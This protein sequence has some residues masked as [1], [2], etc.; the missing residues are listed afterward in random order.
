MSVKSKCHACLLFFIALFI[1]PTLK[2]RSQEITRIQANSLIKKLHIQTT[3]TGKFNTLVNLAWF[4]ILKPG[5]LKTDLDSAKN[6][7]N[8]AGELLNRF[9]SPEFSGFFN[10]VYSDYYHESGQNKIS[11]DAL[12]KATNLL[13][14]GKNKY[15]L[16]RAYQDSMYRMSDPESK[17]KML[18]LAANEFRLEGNMRQ[19]G[20]CLRLIADL[21]SFEPNNINAGLL[22]LDS[23]KHLYQQ[24]RSGDWQQLY[25]VYSRYYALQNN[26]KKSLEAILNALRA[27]DIK[28]T[29][30]EVCELDL[31]ASD[32]FTKL[33]DPKQAL[34]YG[35]SALRLAEKRNNIADIYEISVAVTKSYYD[36]GKPEQGLKLLDALEFKYPV[37]KFDDQSLAHIYSRLFVYNNL[38]LYDKGLPYFNLLKKQIKKRILTDNRSI[39]QALSQMIMFCIGSGRYDQARKMLDAYE[40]TLKK[41]G[42]TP[43]THSRLLTKRLALDTATKD[44]KSAM[45]HLL[46]LKAIS[47]TIFNVTQTRQLKELEIQ[48]QTE[49]KENENSL[50]KQKILT[51]TAQQKFEQAQLKTANVTRNVL[52]LSALCVIVIAGMIYRQYIQGQKNNTLIAE[53]NNRL[54][55]LLSE[56]QW[57]LKEVH[58]RVKNNLQVITALLNSQSAYLE[59]GAALDAILKS[60]GRVE[61]IA[62]I[63]QKLYKANN[64]SS[65]FMPEYI[66]DLIKYLKESFIEDQ[67]IWFDLNVDA[68]WL[69]VADAV[70]VG[71]IINESVTNAIK[72]AFEKRVDN[73]IEISLKKEGAG[74]I[75]VVRDNGKGFPETQSAKNGSFGLLLMTGLADELNGE[76]ERVNADGTLIRVHFRSLT[77]PPGISSESPDSI[78]NS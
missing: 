22:E 73:R 15:L 37:G 1:L 54:E 47:D 41:S 25:I 70:P 4:Q 66:Q 18:R 48:Y 61:S 50:Q 46:E 59:D 77:T 10:L 49:R 39:A 65:I 31:Q 14:S 60:K 74:L 55:H 7:L 78:K 20:D 11:H 75:L 68:V 72:H 52:M 44:Y 17:T 6:Y 28:D 8:Q 57:L 53:K 56:N 45:H 23:A 21:H 42:L 62:L 63:H 29:S 71:L 51:L 36:L 69:D 40:T 3:D 38:K 58:H 5:E 9:K 43:Y 76:L 34:T 30:P 24:A 26:Y 13:K 16:G 12:V 67:N 64:Y 35:L 19:L 27:T 33:A 2:A 32:L